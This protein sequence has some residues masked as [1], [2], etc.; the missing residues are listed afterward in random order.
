TPRSRLLLGKNEYISP[1]IPVL[2]TRPSGTWMRSYWVSCS[3]PGHRRTKTNLP[4]GDQPRLGRSANSFP[5]R[6]T[7]PPILPESVLR[8]TS[9]LGLYRKYAICS[10]SRDTANAIMLSTSEIRRT[11]LRPSRD[12]SYSDGVGRDRSPGPG[13]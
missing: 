13:R 3:G 1:V 8:I 2:S 4:S 6:L 9:L 11:A 7:S 12:N 5:S 10:P